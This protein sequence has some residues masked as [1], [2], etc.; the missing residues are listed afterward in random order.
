MA[1]DSC[2]QLANHRQLTV[3]P[4]IG[5]EPS[6]AEKRVQRVVLEHQMDIIVWRISANGLVISDGHSKKAIIFMH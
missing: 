6:P 5:Q 4:S 1:V 3:N 2:T